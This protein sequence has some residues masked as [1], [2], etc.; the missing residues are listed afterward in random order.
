MWFTVILSYKLR[1]QPPKIIEHPT[2]SIIPKHEPAT[3]N[4]KA[5]GSPTPTI[6]WY[7]DGVPLKILPGSHRVLLLSGGLFFLKS[8]LVKKVG[9][10]PLETAQPLETWTAIAGVF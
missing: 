2:D 1:F 8:Y 5:E 9:S 4:C 7:K 3:L 10:T 6:Q